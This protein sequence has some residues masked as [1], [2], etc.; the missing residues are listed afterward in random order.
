[1]GKPKVLVLLMLALVSASCATLLKGHTD[2]ITVISEPAGAKVSVNGD[3]K[4]TTPV[5]FTVPS[6]EDLNV[7]VVKDG[8]RPEDI[9]D[10]AKTRWGYEAFSFVEWVVPV[11]I[12][13]GTGAAWGHDQLSLTT[14]LEPSPQA[15][16]G[17]A[18]PSVSAQAAPSIEASP[19]AN[20]SP[21]AEATPSASPLS[22][23]NASPDAA[24][25]VSSAAQLGAGAV[26][27]K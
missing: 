27:A 17:A 15:S 7:H 20:A 6:K 12:D 25:T 10:P 26:S 23:A 14:H 19:V 4:G 5:T 18:A 22:A 9:N 2:E 8:Y 13:M 16:P 1:M 21:S 24:A 11:F 3:D